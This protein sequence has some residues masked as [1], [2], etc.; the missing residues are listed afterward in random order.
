MGIL[1]NDSEAAWFDNTALEITT[2]AGVDNTV[3][4]HFVAFPVG[5]VSGT[6]DCLYSEPQPGSKHYFPFKVLG[7]FEAPTMTQEASELGLDIYSEGRFYF[8]RKDLENNKVPPDD[9][10]NHVSP[11]DIVQIFRKGKFWYF[12]LKNIE[13]TGWAND[14]QVWTHYVCDMIRRED[15]NPERNISGE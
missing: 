12:D 8:V 6:V 14:S 10:G 13:R 3:L 7:W 1:L 5:S 2:L 4:W 15:F 11:G 9:L